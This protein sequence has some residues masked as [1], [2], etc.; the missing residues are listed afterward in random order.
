MG[1]KTDRFVSAIPPDAYCVLCS[2]VLEDPIEII[3][4]GHLICLKCWEDS[5]S[6]NLPCPFCGNVISINGVRKSM[7]TWNLIK[8]MMVFCARKD[9]GCESIFKYSDEELH[10]QECSYELTKQMGNANVETLSNCTTCGI[11]YKDNHDCINALVDR[12]KQQSIRISNLEMENKKIA[13]H[14]AIRERI[15]PDSERC[16]FLPT[17]L[18][19]NKDTDSLTSLPSVQTETPRC[20]I[21]VSFYYY[22]FIY[23]INKSCLKYVLLDNFL[24]TCFIVFNDLY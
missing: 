15:H 16:K 19:V 10:L 11:V 8:N 1:I 12:L 3:E 21:D 23:I 17:T 2:K 4:C 24:F 9:S 7:I 13:Y 18:N 5:G 14:L 6:K 20:E 22:F